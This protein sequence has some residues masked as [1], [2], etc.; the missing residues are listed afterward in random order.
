MATFC[1]I[2]YTWQAN[3]NNTSESITGG[4]SGYGFTSAPTTYDNED[5]CFSPPAS[6]LLVDIDAN[7][8]ADMNFQYDALGRRVAQATSMSP[9]KCINIHGSWINLT[10]N[11]TRVYRS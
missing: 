4:M 11:E 3:K 5:L 2:A 10:C 6:K 9:W 1:N 8:T 7:G